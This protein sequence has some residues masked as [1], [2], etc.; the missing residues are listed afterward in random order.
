MLENLQELSRSSRTA[1]W[2]TLNVL[3]SH[4]QFFPDCVLAEIA[5]QGILAFMPKFSVEL[6]LALEV[7][8]RQCLIVVGFAISD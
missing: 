4:G 3:F 6:I 8:T 5:I 7:L 1:L 2:V